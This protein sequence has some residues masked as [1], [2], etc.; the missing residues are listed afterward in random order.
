[1]AVGDYSG[2]WG[3]SGAETGFMVDLGEFLH[4][5]P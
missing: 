5:H 4:G 3:H 1:M 2:M